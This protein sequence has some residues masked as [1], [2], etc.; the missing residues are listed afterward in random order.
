MN[1]P[2]SWRRLWAR[3]ASGVVARVFV[4]QSGFSVLAIAGLVASLA[5]V[6][7]AAVAAPRS[8]AIHGIT[9]R[10]VDGDS[11]WFSPIKRGQRRAPIEVRLARIDAPEICQPHGR[12]SQRALVDLALN[13]PGRL[14]GVARDRYGRLVA[15]LSVDGADVA[16]RMVEEG[17]AWSA[18]QRNDYGPLVKQE[19]M[20][21]AL[22]R[23][24]HAHQG[25]V[26]PS[27]FRQDRGSCVVAADTEKR[28]ATGGGAGLR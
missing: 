11:L 19:R 28:P 15:H 6:S 17:Q 7:P 14:Q 2:D 13:K 5:C 16:T 27:R 21:R 22:A 3:P 4:A 18:R 23:G 8:A 9:T 20:A 25:A 26:Q 12:E 24:L 1:D 10:V